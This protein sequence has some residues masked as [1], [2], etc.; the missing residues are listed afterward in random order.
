LSATFCGLETQ[1][2]LRL[3]CVPTAFMA[4]V[5]KTIKLDKA[6]KQM[7]LD[8][9]EIEQTGRY[10]TGPKTALL[11][12][13]IRILEEKVKEHAKTVEILVNEQKR[14]RNFTL[15][16]MRHKRVYMPCDHANG[17]EYT[18][19]TGSTTITTTEFVTPNTDPASVVSQFYYD[20]TET[21]TVRVA[22]PATRNHYQDAVAQKIVM[23]ERAFTT[24]GFEEA[25]ASVMAGSDEEGEDNDDNDSKNQENVVTAKQE[26]VLD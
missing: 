2:D 21:P 20:I 24:A 1:S 9:D 14:F 18:T 19:T 16:D 4:N 5:S 22:P 12:E 25:Y 6:A 3:Y 15:R 13:R 26:S 7:V 17:S 8:M 23:N 10:L 11:K